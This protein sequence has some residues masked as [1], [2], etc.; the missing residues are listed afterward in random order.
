[1]AEQDS[2]IKDGDVA[3]VAANDAQRGLPELLGRVQYGDELVKITKNGKDAAALVPVRYLE[4]IIEGRKA[5]AK[6]AA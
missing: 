2:E 6:S 4:Q 3:E 5:D 1:M